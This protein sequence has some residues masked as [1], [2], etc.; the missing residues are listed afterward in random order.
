M[1]ITITCQNK[2]IEVLMGRGFSVESIKFPGMSF[3]GIEVRVK[4]WR[5]RI[6]IDILDQISG[7]C[8]SSRADN[9]VVRDE[10]S[11]FLFSY[12]DRASPI[13]LKQPNVYFMQPLMVTVRITAVTIWL[14]TVV[15][16]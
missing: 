13:G 2:V 5:V 12:D 14:Q 1:M 9:I 3:E 15:R 10:E 8:L 7:A 16:L 11:Y 6:Y 4:P